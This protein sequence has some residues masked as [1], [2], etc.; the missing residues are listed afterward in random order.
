VKKT[1]LRMV[2]AILTLACAV[3]QSSPQKPDAESILRQMTLEEKIDYLGGTGFAIRAMPWLGLPAFE[4][5]DGP[6]GVRSN[7]H[8]PSTTYAA[9][10]GLAAT[11]NRDLAAQVGEGIGKD[12]RA[13]G[14]HFML[15]PGVNIYRSPVNGRNFEYLGEDP[16]LASSIA[17]GYIT[18]MQKE[19]VSATVKHFLGNN[20]EFDRHHSDS[21]IDERALRE[22]YLPVFEAAVKQAH[23]G[24]IMDSYNL[25]NGQHMTQNGYFNTEVVRKE[26]GFDGVLMSD[27]VATYDGVAAANNGLDLEMPFGM[28]MKRANLLPAISDGRVKVATLDEKIRH[29]LHTAERF[30]WLSGKQLELSLSSY[31]RPNQ[32][33]ALEAARESM[34][35]LKNEN[36]L[37]PLDK[38]KIKSVLVVGP[39]AYPAV[40]VGGGSA[41]V[42]PFAPVSILEGVSKLLGTT[43]T[44]Y[45]QRGL[46]TIT[47]L[48]ATTEFMTAAQNGAPGLK[49]E[50]FDN[51]ELSGTPTSSH[52]LNH[53]NQPGVTFDDLDLDHLGELFGHPKLVSR[54]WTGVYVAPQAGTYELA[55]LGA[56]EDSGFRISVDGKWRIDAW[57]TA[58]TLQGSAV[59]ELTAGPH[60]VV[61]EDFQRGPVGGRLR[62]GIANQQTVVTE[63]ARKQA[64]TVDA[65]IVAGGF[66]KDSESEGADRSFTLPFGQDELIREMAAANPK[67]IVAVTSGGNV[68]S[69]RWL[70]EVPAL[71]EM[72][73]P[74]ESGGTALAEILF[75]DVNPSGRLPVTFE[76]RRED[77]P[78][79]NSYYPKAGSKQV[80]YSEG[81][82][83]GYRGYERNK[84]QPL[85]PFGYG[86]SYTTFKYSNL[87]LKDVSDGSGPRFEA[88]FDVT[89]TG[90]REG[91][92]VAQ[93]YISDGH[94]AVARP[95]KE[96]KGFAKVDLKPGET[97]TLTI[98]LDTRSLAYYDVA[99][100]QW[101]AEA[102]TFGVLV[103]SSSADI[104]LTGEIKLLAT[105]T[106][107]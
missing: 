15:G 6:I 38:A 68:D 73:F 2:S 21:V 58:R 101:R 55:A 71:L 70:G 10:I 5:S 97:Q 57:E 16:F 50:F 23:V 35:L 106:A 13:R 95:P 19:D 86:L 56:G 24:A 72:W 26:W 27:W 20:S 52:V 65:V 64:A 4:M 75:G 74:G 31:S 14:V 94:S 105:A 83:V 17:V 49:V 9:G 98:P 93:L 78:T 89:N 76:K 32:L 22:I 29:I 82:F 47:Q 42:Q 7:S 81:V 48:A 3:A 53:I 77:N 63:A 8:F 60:Q 54:R 85:F 28:F 41:S 103:G 40:P 61:V 1:F 44:V 100:R 90:D 25:V 69:S 67:T 62:I 59:L 84:V 80:V 39:D 45:Y 66:D 92:E 51:D 34:V 88:S 18:G 37:L 104:E 102:G 30:G 43:A 96:L 99:G 46:P 79:F 91:K 11:W 36:H 33:L 87:K 107:K 12:A